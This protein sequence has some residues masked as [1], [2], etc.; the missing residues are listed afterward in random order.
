MAACSTQMLANTQK[1][2]EE[3]RKKGI[4]SGHTCTMRCQTVFFIVIHSINHLMMYPHSVT[5]ASR[6]QV[7]GTLHLQATCNCTPG[8]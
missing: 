3:A 7:Q 1:T 8:M 4:E 2:V 6:L 5:S